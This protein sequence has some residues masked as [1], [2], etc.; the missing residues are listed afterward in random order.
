MV[1]AFRRLSEKLKNN[2]TQ[3]PLRLCGDEII[4]PAKA[5][6]G[7]GEKPYLPPAALRQWLW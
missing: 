5:S 3:R 2:K 4:A 6:P 1:L 7:A